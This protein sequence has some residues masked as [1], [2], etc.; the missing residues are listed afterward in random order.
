MSEIVH[1]EKLLHSYRDP[2]GR[3]L[4]S[5]RGVDFSL[6]EGEF[7]ILLGPTGSGKSTLLQHMNGLI[8]PQKGIV[9]VLGQ[10]LSSPTANLNEIRSRVGLVFQ[11]PEDQLFERYVGDDIA[12]GPRKQGASGQ[13]LRDEVR[14][15]ME[16]V[17]LDFEAYKDRPVHALSGGERRKVGLAGVLS[18]RPRVLLLD[19]PTAGLDPASRSTLMSQLEKLLDEGVS[20]VIST[21][22]LDDV[23]VRA[24]RI[25]VLSD[26]QMALHGSAQEVVTQYDAMKKLGMGVPTCTELLILLKRKGWDVP[27]NIVSPTAAIAKITDFIKGR[28][29]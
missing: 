7:V 5:L 1:I 26:G 8:L 3:E 20:L 22:N 11:R 28:V 21:H 15:A 19:E 23:V 29:Q 17:G 2:L 10:D 24:D 12:Y 14:W 27:D 6:N 9:R 18:L 4:P 25:Y 13:K 16:R